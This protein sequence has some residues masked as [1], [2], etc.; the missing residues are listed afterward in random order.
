MTKLIEYFTQL[1]GMGTYAALAI[2][3]KENIDI[4][5]I[6]RGHSNPPSLQL[7]F[8]IKLGKFRA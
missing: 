6:E 5:F 3:K 7:V 8:V 4:T 1:E 2:R